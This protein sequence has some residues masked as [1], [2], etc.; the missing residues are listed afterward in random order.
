MYSLP[1]E[2]KIDIFKFL[3]FDKLHSVRQ[4]NWHFNAVIDKYE[5]EFA[6][7]TL[8]FLSL[9]SDYFNEKLDKNKLKYY[10]CKENK[11]WFGKRIWNKIW[12]KNVKEVKKCNC[13]RRILSNEELEP[14]NFPLS[15][16]LLEKWQTAIDKQIPIYLNIDEEHPLDENIAIILKNFRYKYS[17]NFALKLPVFPKNIEEMKIVRCWFYRLFQCYFDKTISYDLYF[18]FNPE[19]IKILFDNDN[20]KLVGK[21]I[22][23]NCLTQNINS[24]KFIVDYQLIIENVRIDFDPLFDDF[25]QYNKYLFKILINGGF[26]MAEIS[27]RFFRRNNILFNWI[28]NYIEASKDLTKMVDNILLKCSGFFN[29]NLKER[30]KNMRIK[31]ETIYY[32]FANIYNPEMKYYIIFPERSDNDSDFD[33]IL[34]IAKVW[35]DNIEYIKS[36]NNLIVFDSLCKLF[37]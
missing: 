3:N 6:R 5:L 16:Q 17:Q 28:I 29:L 9:V 26:K 25:E 13:D 35:G 34:I 19:M 2:V 32:A 33:D 1:I 11:F 31:E 7:K 4:I 18:I 36:K 21:E 27:S 10:K 8:S 15:N 30:G 37:I 14:F 12:K 24:L 23:F 22:T 20:L